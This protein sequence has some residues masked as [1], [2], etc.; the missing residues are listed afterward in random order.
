[1]VPTRDAGRTCE[2]RGGVGCQW[3]TMPMPP[4]AV[5]VWVR[6]DGVG[7]ESQAGDAEQGQ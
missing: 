7:A 5:L 4:P 6:G 2:A 1:M 3:R